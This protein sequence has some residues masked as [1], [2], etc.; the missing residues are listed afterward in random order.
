M[1]HFHIEG[2]PIL[3]ENKPKHKGHNVH[4]GGRE[5]SFAGRL[6]LVVSN[7]S[8]RIWSLLQRA[9]RSAHFIIEPEGVSLLDKGQRSVK[10]LNS[11]FEDVVTTDL[12]LTMRKRKASEHLENMSEGGWASLL[13]EA[14]PTGEHPTPSH[15]Y[16]NLVKECLR[17]HWD[18]TPV[19]FA[20]VVVALR[21]RGFEID[22][23]SGR[24][25]KAEPG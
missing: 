23:A 11:G 20:G 4:K 8:G 21:E 3:A 15:V 12:I 14:V 9:I 17:R 1:A 22:A 10:G 6:S 7:S 16:L 18:L 2:S 13:A 19:S 5:T 25:S 24:F